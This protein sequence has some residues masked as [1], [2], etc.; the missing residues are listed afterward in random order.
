[1]GRPGL[2]QSAASALT[3]AL[4]REAQRWFL[5]LPVLFACGIAL[6]FSLASEPGSRTVAALL[7]A[8]A[9]C[10]FLARRRALGWPLA[11]ACL[12]IVSGF[13]A[14]KL[15]LTAVD[16]PMLLYKSGAVILRGWVEEIRTRSAKAHRILVKVAAI[17]GR[18]DLPALNR[19]R[20]SYRFADPP[21]AGSAIRLRA[22]LLPPPGPVIPGGFDF[23]RAAWFSGIGAVGFALQPARPWADAPPRSAGD[24]IRSA[25]A[26]LR[27]QVDARI[28]TALPDSR[29]GVASA[30][31]TGKRGGIEDSHLQAL[32][33]SG[34]AHLL[35]ISGMHMVILAGS[36]FWLIRALLAANPAIA[37]R[38]PV[39]KISAII[40]LGGGGFY[41]LLSGMGI[42][43]QRAYLMMAIMFLAVLLDRPAI[44][45]RNVAMAALIILVIHPESLFSVSFQMSFSA[46]LGLVAFYERW[47]RA[48]AR[49][50]PPLRAAGNPVVQLAVRVLKYGVGIAV[51]TLVA[52]IAVAP[53][54]AYHFH[55]LAQ[56]SLIAN[57]AAMPVFGL[58]V[59]PMALASLLAMPFGLEYWPLQVMAYGIS[60]IITVAQ[61]VSGWEGAVIRLQAMPGHSL[62]LL[63]AGGLWLILW[64]SR[65]RHAGLVIAAAGILL[66]GSAERPDVLISRDAKVVAVRTPAGQLSAH[67]DRGGAYSLERWLAADGDKRNP[68][69]A[70]K[71]SVFRCDDVACLATVKG[72]TIAI[73]LH[74]AAIREECATA[75]IVVAQ[76]PLG[77]NRARC[78]GARRHFDIIDLERDGATALYLEGHAIRSATA[79]QKRGNWPWTGKTHALARQSVQ[80]LRGR[81]AAARAAEKGS[82]KQAAVER[83]LSRRP[84]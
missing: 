51:T 64:Q 42:A 6:C 67:M 81:G 33:H 55:Q 82:R 10:A 60:L 45:L 72:N 34:L 77:H 13:A 83:R 32:R 20:I 46:A 9:G 50:S 30:L 5:W 3:N 44:T 19:V 75:D 41:L 7:L 57:L 69:I 78:P 21:S 23:A 14:A 84:Q 35:A 63:V 61:T 43:T 52:S 73:L 59:M 65:W 71:D 24:K 62:L 54:A 8:G 49:H 70:R 80:P 29:G 17:E 11:I 18:P 76:F 25:V 28:R 27:Q 15:R 4:L 31:L 66:A 48:Q 12:A 1:M 39:K 74:P 36:L 26:R 47:S 2:L 79:A 56:Y 53:F 37:L 58:L 22:V 40:A 16:T 38:Y 68:E